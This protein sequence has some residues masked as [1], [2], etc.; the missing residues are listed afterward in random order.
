MKNLLSLLLLSLLIPVMTFANIKLVNSHQIQKK[1]NILTIGDSNGALAYGWPS[2]IK[3]LLPD[4]TLINRSISGNTIG[5]DNNDQVKLNT[6]K[7]IDRYLEEAF[8]ELGDGKKFDYI[9]MVLGTNDTKTVFENRQKEVSENIILLIHKIKDYIT[10]HNMTL[11]KIC[12]VTP[13]PMDEEKAD[14][15]KYGGG[16]G[17]IQMNNIEFKRIAKE[18]KIDFLD[19]YS[20]LKSGF[21]QNTLDGVHLVEKAQIQ[22]ATEI[23]KYIKSK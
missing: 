21:S 2:Q 18:N 20:L 10:S 3:N 22:V 11:P 15:V 7:N 14:K 6:L 5:F 9:V 16:D 4:A 1:L 13:S 12:I 17:R 19:T 8:K 23:V